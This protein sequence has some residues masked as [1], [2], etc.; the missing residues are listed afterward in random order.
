[1]RKLSRRFVVSPTPEAYTSKTDLVS[2]DAGAGVIAGRGEGNP[3]IV[4][5]VGR[6]IDVGGMLGDMRRGMG[7]VGARIA[8]AGDTDV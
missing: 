7:V 1:M 8:G 5:S 6:G 3:V 2:I 4:D